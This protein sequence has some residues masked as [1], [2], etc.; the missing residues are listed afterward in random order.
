M[1]SPGVE[2]KRDDGHG[3]DGGR[4]TY[5]K[6]LPCFRPYRGEN[7]KYY[8]LR[9][10]VSSAP[11][12]TDEDLKHRHEYGSNFIR[13]TRYRW[14]NF[15]FKNLFEQFQK[16][17]NFYFLIMAII[18]SVP[19]VS[20]IPPYATITP[21]AFVLAVTAIK[22]GIDDYKRGRNDSEVNARRTEVLKPGGGTT[23]LTWQDLQV[24][25]VVKVFQDGIF[26]AD[27]VLLA[28]STPNG[29]CG[30]QTAN[31]DGETNIKGRQAVKDT[32]KMTTEELASP[33]RLRVLCERP[34]TGKT[35]EGRLL[36]GA[37]NDKSFPLNGDNILLRGAMLK[38]TK[39]I[40]GL[41]IYTGSQ[42]K[43]ILHN[44]PPRFK[45]SHMDDIMNQQMY[46]IFLLQFCIVFTATVLS[47]WFFVNRGRNHWYLGI[48]DDSVSAGT[49]T[50]LRN[51]FAFY[52]LL[53]VMVPISLYVSMELVR[54]GQAILIN[55]D[56][57]MW[58]PE[59]GKFAQARSTTLSEELGQIQYIFSDK[60]GTLTSNQMAFEKSSILGKLYG[61]N[62]VNAKLEAKASLFTAGGSPR[63]N[64]DKEILLGEGGQTSIQNS[65]SVLNEQQVVSRGISEDHI[66]ID[67][68]PRYCN[69]ND[70]QLRRALMDD[71]P[72]ARDYVLALALCQ[73]VQVSEIPDRPGKVQYQGESTDE[74]ALVTMASMHGVRFLEK[75][76][77]EVTLWV[78]WIPDSGGNREGKRKGRMLGSAVVF[79]ILHVLAFTSDRK[80]MSVLV[81]FPDGSIRVFTKGADNVMKNIAAKNKAVNSTNVLDKTESHLFQF[82]RE[83]LR[84]ML[85]G[86]RHLDT[87]EYESWSTRYEE[88]S[89][90][91]ADAKG[92]RKDKM[93]RIAA[94]IEQNLQI[95]GVTAIEDKLQD[96]VP[97]TLKLLKRAGI[98]IWVLTGDKQNTAVNIGKSCGLIGWDYQ[99]VY[100]RSKQ[101][102]ECKEEML[103]TLEALEDSDSDEA[104]LMVSGDSLKAALL[105]GNNGTLFDVMNH[106][107]I[108]VVVAS[109]M[110]PRQKREIV[111][112]VKDRLGVV[113]LAIGD[114]ANDVSMIRAAHIGV[115]IR[116]KEGMQA[117]NSS[118]YAIS[119]FRFLAQLLLVHGG[120]S[121]Q[122][123]STLIL[124][125]FYKNVMMAVQQVYFIFVS[126]YSSGEVF[127]GYMLNTFNLC[128]T[129]LPILFFS[130]FDRPANV[131]E[132][133]EF[134]Q[135]Y[136]P[137]LRSEFFNFRT[138][139][140]SF[141]EA[142]IHGSVVWLVV[143]WTMHDVFDSYWTSSVATYTSIVIVANIKMAMITTTW[144]WFN[145]LI[146]ILTVLVYFGYIFLHCGPIGFSFSP[147]LFGVINQVMLEPMFYL[148]TLWL[149]T[150]VVLQDFMVA[151]IQRLTNP[152][153]QM[154]VQECRGDTIKKQNL[155]IALYESV[156]QKGIW[157][158][159]RGKPTGQKVKEQKMK[160][161]AT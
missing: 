146:I 6:W 81:L 131:D 76:R 39:F 160:M 91:F 133:I 85:V 95:L 8:P 141:G 48:E 151:Y 7:G 12:S 73:T 10:V 105:P 138:F 14:W 112:L 132:L 42:T 159:E 115:G 66:E 9:E 37:E 93:E 90:S 28:S 65:R 69:M 117:A 120:L 107:K 64:A 94:E 52:V 58:D 154:L 29:E 3:T 118:D 72:G 49:T 50:A 61:C 104:A 75:K 16:A 125:F 92:N 62:E 71:Y 15:L 27:L 31:L 53:S 77:N 34:H 38:E 47:G 119:K 41:V 135:L 102:S 46:L 121:Y 35:F 32:A 152:S 68:D 74:V 19:G 1:N 2:G 149:A 63:R 145:A 4:S 161:L 88:A 57:R 83:G 5:L 33:G 139:W 86:Q 130:V 140:I 20:T 43:V 114:G 25:H 55:V 136:F 84:V 82:S 124:Y 98:K 30:I 137:G 106:R 127:D 60:T 36:I 142:V 108:K 153:L 134:P 143:W 79:K 13:T 18:T 96:G 97:L 99:L 147:W 24:G 113:T 17:A 78:P 26:P 67:G 101:P 116:G 21:L 54:V 51:F 59:D 122:R 111:T 23:A 45:R 126:G 157:M 148:A 103:A 56:N 22:D 11:F 158:N 144:F 89:H 70:P 123:N 156:P 87:K 150:C 40:Y 155:K 80:R 129:S 109:R 128:W 100:I 110:T 44:D